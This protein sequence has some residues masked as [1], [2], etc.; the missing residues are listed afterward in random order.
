MTVSD[1]SPTQNADDL[2]LAAAAAAGD[3]RSRRIVSAR[4][5]ALIRKRTS[6]LC[7]RYC[8][9]N[10][11][12]YICTIDPSW[13]RQPRAALLCDVGNGSYEFMLADLA[14]P[15]SLRAYGARNG[16]SLL[17][18][19]THVAMSP[20]FLARWVRWRLGKRVR[21]PDYVVALGDPDIKTIFWWL[22]AGHTL[23]NIAQRLGRDE[24]NVVALYRKINAALVAKGCT[25]QLATQETRSLNTFY[26]ADDNGDDEN[27]EWDIPAQDVPFEDIELHQKARAAVA[28]LDGAERFVIEELIVN[29]RPVKAVLQALREEGIAI[30]AGAA[31]AEADEQQVY[32]FCR[33]ALAKLRKKLER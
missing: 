13:G 31:P 24:E 3:E 25:F 16:A 6:E 32:Y 8:R 7:K 28:L 29:G 30:K 5:D 2:A 19:V 9:D 11:R 15:T 33:K 1:P 23:A 26:A 10:R 21:V 18:Y 14:S 12:Q 20:Q 17:T 22:C 4:F 27:V